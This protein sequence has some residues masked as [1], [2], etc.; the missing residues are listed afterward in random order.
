MRSACVR[1]I[2]LALLLPVAALA[3]TGDACP[4]AAQD[5][6][7]PAVR[8]RGFEPP[9]PAALRGTD[10]GFGEESA[11]PDVAPPLPGDDPSAVPQE[12]GDDDGTQPRQGQRPVLKDGDL[13]DPVV[14]M[15]R[16]G[17]IDTSEP[18]APTDGADPTAVDMRPKEEA[19]LF[20]A[21]VPT[22]DALLFQIEELEPILDKRPQ[23]LFRFEPYDP[24][25]VKA[26][27]F[28]LFPELEIGGNGF[29]N[30]FRAPKARP[31][32]SFDVRPSARLVSNW[33][34]H[35]LEFSA[36]GTFSSYDQFSTEN[37][38]SYTL[39]ARG[40]LDVSKRTNLQA[41]VS[42]DV[43]QESRT[44][45]EARAAGTRAD[46]TTDAAAV[47]LNHRFNRLGLQLRG[48]VTDRT[49]GASETGGVATLNDARN[50]VTYEQAVRASWEIKPTLSAFTDVAINQRDYQRL[51]ATGID[52]SSTGER[53]R[54]GLSFGSTGEFL[55]GEISAGWGAQHP[56]NATLPDVSGV[57]V[58]ANVTYRPTALTA[59]A[60]TARSDFGE[61]TNTGSG[62]V[63]SQFVGVE[64]RHAFRRDV[65]ATAGLGFTGSDYTGTTL[66][67]EELRAT[68]GVEY[69][70]NRDTVLFSRYVHTAFTS[71]AANANYDA[72]EIRV[73]VRL[74]R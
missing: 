73:G 21:P 33:R 64:G 6:T 45:L 16:D 54:A 58:D 37:E 50:F 17:I 9:R 30:V 40:R 71:N 66:K 10:G 19:D 5:G 3:V 38:V 52:R 39:E 25:G 8:R 68:L 63:K 56:A 74:R 1:T 49:Y 48:S 20:E 24:V 43:S 72:D 34:R 4:A 15:L 27:S 53:Y 47:A 14:P 67:E 69:F 28:V 36:R 13:S 62:G 65:I 61:T 51:D 32:F 23:R 59:V 42:R 35:A 18:A 70:V 11:A 26:G 44:V 57:I 22:A 55:R 60:L 12:A 41:T 29:S 46:V 2:G 31:D 7:A